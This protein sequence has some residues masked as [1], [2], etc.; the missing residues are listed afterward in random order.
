MAAHLAGEDFKEA[1]RVHSGRDGLTHF[2]GH[3]RGE[4]C[5][6]AGA[7]FEVHIEDAGEEPI[8]D[9]EVVGG[10][11]CDG[12]GGKKGFLDGSEG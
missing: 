2:F 10:E 12:V 7:G 4:A 3:L 9:G 6:D 5:G 1:L 8:D 11:A